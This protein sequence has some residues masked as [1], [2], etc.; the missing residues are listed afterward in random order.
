MAAVE[1]LL[2][3]KVIEDQD[4][5]ELLR[6]GVRAYHF[7]GEWEKMYQFILDHNSKHGAVPSERQFRQKYGDVDIE[8]TSQ[9]TFS[10]L[11]EELFA[12]YRKRMV[13]GAISDAMG[14]LD[15]GKTDE[16]ITILADGLG[17]AKASTITVKDTN[18]ITSWEE[19]LARYDEMRKSPNALRGIPTGFYGLDKITHG[20]RPG[21]WIIL[22]GEQKR[23]KSII[24]LIMADAAQIH[25]KRVGLVSQ[26]MNGHEQTSRYDAYKAGI[27]YNDILAG[28]LSQDQMDR[29][30]YVLKRNKNSEDF[31]IFE[32]ASGLTTVS[33]L[34]AKVIEHKLDVLFVDGVYLMDD[35]QGS[36]ARGDLP[37]ALRN[38]SQSF[39]RMSM[40][41]DIP[42]IGTTQAL[43]WKL[44]NKRTRALTSDAL[45]FTTAFQQDGDLILGVER[46]PDIDNQSIIRVLDARTAPR[47]EVHIQFDWSTMSFEEVEINGP[48][49]PAFL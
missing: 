15:K 32:D 10:G 33:A 44:N 24:L 37:Q 17:E 26:E 11:I 7:A 18:V 41:L 40:D 5:T 13:T 49:D 42:I 19:R 35:E 27:D 4:V 12:A 23:G 20:L 28:T 3:S 46:N 36:K 6:D 38:I 9:E 30:E 22:G 47:A 14:V 16:A 21:Q 43:G 2:I 34:R 39:K 29:L 45:G 8:D 25:G 1:H 48:I 31:F